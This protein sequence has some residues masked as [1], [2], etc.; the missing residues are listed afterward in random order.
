MTFRANRVCPNSQ[1]IL[2]VGL[3]GLL[4]ACS[5]AD[6]SGRTNLSTKEELTVDT[7]DDDPPQREI[8]VATEP[9]AKCQVRSPGT[10]KP[11]Q[12]WADDSGIVHLW[13]P[14]TAETDLLECT[15]SGNTVE[16]V[17]DLAAETTFAPAVPRFV[18]SAR[19]VL[20]A[21]TNPMGPRQDELI[22]AGY[23]PRPDPMLAAP[24]YKKWLEMVSS[25]AVLVQ[26]NLVER[27]EIHFWNVTYNS[28][29]IWGGTVMDV[30]NTR[31]VWALGAFSVP[32]FSSNGLPSTEIAMWPGLDGAG[33]PDVIQDGVYYG[34]SGS[35]GSYQAWHEYYPRDPVTNTTMVVS[36]G[37]SMTFWAWEGD[38]SCVVGAGHTGYGCFWYKNNTTGVQTTTLNVIAPNGLFVGKTG[39][40]IIER[41]GGGTGS[42][43]SKFTSLATMEM[44]AVDSLGGGHNIS[45]DHFQASALN[46]NSGQTLVSVSFCCTDYTAW[47]WV[48][49]Q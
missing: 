2:V 25:P 14:M 38:S 39:E 27:P 4:S 8:T 35:T 47:T 31:Y 13:A 6:E 1:G 37:N 32:S 7:P 45:G 29:N 49:S 48:R 40:A 44:A 18:S 43:V 15:E 16:H 21:L 22:A 23:P 42:P 17:L 46:N 24:L 28:S 34:S 10:Q 26:P 30:V 20:P 9:N 33:T 5:A 41:V 12:V 3:A 11:M 19:S 36:P